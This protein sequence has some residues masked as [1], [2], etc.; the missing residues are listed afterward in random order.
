VTIAKLAG[1]SFLPALLLMP[2]YSVGQETTSAIEQQATAFLYSH[3]SERFPGAQIKINV[4]ELKSQH[5]HKQCSTKLNF[6]PPRTLSARPLL[7]VSC[8]SPRSWTLYVRADASIQRNAL[9]L[10]ARLKR[11]QRIDASMLQV[12]LVDG[13]RHPDS[14]SSLEQISSM[15]AKRAISSGKVLSSRDVTQAPAISKG[16]AIMIEARRGGLS[17]RTSGTAL[18]SGHIGEQIRA[19]NNRSGKEVRGI[20]RARG[21]IA[22]P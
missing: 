2:L 18:E 21:L 15:V 13:F 6:Q 1:T 5:K 9:V 7:K 20:I 4:S 19:T 11:G 10:K 3:Y 14:F 16:D 8:E 22:V 12:K 17:I